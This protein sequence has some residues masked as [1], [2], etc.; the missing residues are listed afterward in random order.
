MKKKAIGSLLAITMVSCATRGTAASTMTPIRQAPT[1][2][3]EAMPTVTLSQ[4]PT[5]NLEV[6]LSVTPSP[7]PTRKA[8]VILTPNSVEVKRW[9]EYQSALARKLMSFL[10]EDEVLCEWEILGRSSQE[11]YVWVAC[12]GIV[13]I[14]NRGGFPSGEEPAVIHV[15]ADGS[16]QSIEVPG[17]GSDYGRDIR[18]LFPPDVQTKIFDNLIDY[19]QLLDHLEWRRTHPEEPPLIVLSVTPAP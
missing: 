9:G 15:G 12:T 10:P 11:T 19:R 17:A 7:M 1:A 13:P 14:G 18:R 6:G 2:D 8:F 5:V 3:L 4:S 16:V